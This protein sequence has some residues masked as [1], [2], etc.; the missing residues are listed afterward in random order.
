MIRPRRKSD[1]A[2]VGRFRIIGHL[3]TGGFGTVYVADRQKWAN[4]LVAVKVVHQQLAEKQTFRDRFK[5][6]IRAIGRVSSEYV[7]RLVAHGA[8]E[9]TPWLA[10]ELI[11]GPSLQQVVRECGP[12]PESAVWQLG[13]G[14]VEALTA[15][16]QVGLAH[17]DF[18]PG[19]VLIVPEG[20][21][22]IDF[23][24]VH[25]AE[26]DHGSSSRLY[27]GS[28][29]YAPA[30]QL[31][32]LQY[33]GPQADIF[34]LGGTL[35]FA[36]T[37]HPPY[38]SRD[39]AYRAEV[40]LADLP[41][42]FYDA[43]SQCLTTAEHARPALSELKELFENQAGNA[44]G[45]RPGPGGFRDVMPA[46]VADLIGAW[47]RDLS[48]VVHA[49]GNAKSAMHEAWRDLGPRPEPTRRSATDVV[50][51]APR[52]TRRE[53]MTAVQPETVVRLPVDPGTRFV[54]WR[55]QFRDW[56]RAPVAVAANLAA[57]ASLDG[58]VA[59]F[60]A[61]TGELLWVASL[62]VPV[63]SAAALAPR[64]RRAGST[65]YVGDAE[66]GMHV[67][68][69]ASKEHRQLFQAATG[70][71]G[72]PVAVGEHV[73]ALSADGCVYLI[74]ARTS[75]HQLLT[76]LGE[77][78]LGALTAAEGVLFA[79]T[80]TGVIHAIDVNERRER[81]R[82]DV[83]GLVH[84][85]P[86]ARDGWLY[87]AGTDGLLWS[88]SADDGSRPAV[89]EVGAPVHAAPLYDDGRLYI[90]GSDGVVRAFGIAGHRAAQPERL[91]PRPPK[92]G[93][94]VSG[95]AAAGGQVYAATE[96]MLVELDGDTGRQGLRLPV[97]SSVTAAP[98][99]AGDLLYLAG[100]D[101]V[102]SCL[103]MA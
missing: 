92:V 69:V 82:L 97:G 46:S 76:E 39:Q 25:L 15:I 102:V 85:A 3:G 5:R 22:V 50:A 94:G 45:G 4:E 30:E 72:P 81:W 87:L 88:V 51:D 33:A 2:E 20:P 9:D 21:R 6:E 77:P 24:L 54:R 11:R 78:A 44:R 57:A 16:H 96:G 73:Y 49:R 28:Y 56:L 60:A 95:L 63:V 80:A 100:L 71:V 70:I 62:G 61:D 34:T 52:R 90:G 38:A 37:G 68:D 19:N 89:V 17:R 1:P 53:G 23:S 40:D 79:A 18:K 8:D 13:L 10:T 65:V 12:L 31:Q 74:D 32:G 27:M 55:Q 103:S 29:E 14:I 67:L 36:A 47:R 59:F 26:L 91:W 101:G 35:L 42:A 84:S 43:V 75:S 7:P 58:T 66:G 86:V 98:V 48:N 93:D 83:G 64:G 99:A 41:F